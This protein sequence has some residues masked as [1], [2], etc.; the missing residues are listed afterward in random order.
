MTA[1]PPPPPPAL[2]YQSPFGNTDAPLWSNG[3]RLVTLS[4]VVFPAR[5]IKCNG[6]DNLK[7]IKRNLAWSPPWMYILLLCPG[8][9]IGGLIILLT[10]R[11]ASITIAACRACRNKQLKHTL[12]AWGIFLTAILV[13]C[14]A[15]HFESVGLAILGAALILTSAI[16]AIVRCN[17]VTAAKIVD[18]V[19]TI[20]GA[21]APFLATLDIRR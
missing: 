18:N 13:F 12:T 2:G 5:C 17:L 19:V 11:K 10:Q 20:K 15:V 16:Y 3:K 7:T 14:A 21:G 6:A 4:G 1:T 8:L 9:L